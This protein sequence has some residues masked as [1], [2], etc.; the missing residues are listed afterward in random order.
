MLEDANSW[1]DDADKPHINKEEFKKLITLTSITIY[2]DII[3]FYFDDGDI[4]WNHAIVVESDCHFNFT[5]VH[6]EG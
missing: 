3:I 2:E 6:I 4:F 5:D 1:N